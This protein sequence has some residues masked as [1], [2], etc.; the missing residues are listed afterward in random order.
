MSRNPEVAAIVNTLVGVW[1]GRGEGRYPTIEPFIYREETRFAGRDD[2]PSLHYEQRTW[3]PT[4]DGE[5]VS[6]WETGL[7]RI[8]SDGSVSI[9]NA[10]GG[11]AETMSG[12]WLPDGDD[13]IIALTS[14][15]YAGDD[16]VIS[17]SREIR[18]ANSSLSYEM[19]MKTTAIDAMEL[20]L[21]ADLAR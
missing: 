10:Q 7:L 13:W 8:S 5:L 11:R 19:F 4:P 16:R 17:S 15:G 12:T 21:N 9:S 3:R 18:L 14:N 1:T 20:H 6:H 2:H